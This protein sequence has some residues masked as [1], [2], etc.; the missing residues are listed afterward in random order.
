MHIPWLYNMINIIP[1]PLT[2][3]SFSKHLWK[4]KVMYHFTLPLHI[5]LALT[6]LP[7]FS[8]I[9]RKIT[10]DLQGPLYVWRKNI[11]RL[12]VTPNRT[13]SISRGYLKSYFSWLG[14]IFIW[15]LSNVL[16]NTQ[17]PLIFHHDRD[18]WAVTINMVLFSWTVFIIANTH[19]YWQYRTV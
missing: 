19:S 18:F 4:C 13:L 7:Y 15:V 11:Q 8:E 3:H 16:S 1:I 6:H 9:H 17:V 5:L 10:G 2:P 14:G 12:S